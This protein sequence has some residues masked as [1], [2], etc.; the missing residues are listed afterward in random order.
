MII[1]KCFKFKLLPTPDQAAKFRQLGGNTRFTY[2]KLLELSLEQYEKDQNFI[3]GFSLSNQLPGLK[4]K[5]SFLKESYSQSLQGA[6]ENLAQA[7]INKFKHKTSGFP[8]FKKKQ[9]EDSFVYKQNWSLGRN[10]VVLPKI[11]RIRMVKHR[12]VQGRCKT[13]TISQDVD[14]WFAS[15]LCELEVPDPTPGFLEADFVGIDVGIK[16]FAVVSDGLVVEN[17]KFLKKSKSKIARASR[18]LARKV[19]GS[20]NRAKARAKLARAHRTVRRQRADFHHQVSSSMIAKYSGVALE[21]LNIQGMMKNHHLAGAIA[22]CGWGGFVRCLEYKAAWAGKP[23]I[24]VNQ[25]F[26]STQTCSACGSKKPMLLRERTY[27]C[28]SCGLVL[29]RDFN[30]S[31][32]IKTEGLRLLTEAAKINDLPVDSGE[33]ATFQVAAACGEKSSGLLGGETILSE[34]GKRSQGLPELCLAHL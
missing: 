2:N 17:P 9:G 13:I 30:A 15:I 5:F 32:N 25:W 8:N 10:S 3:F 34:S 33:G 11:G 31:Q 29:D 4:K 23:V 7:F 21:T 14:Q 1:Q 22:D 26:A 27:I 6:A 28:T 19:K 12:P 16:E 24:R 18:R 20:S